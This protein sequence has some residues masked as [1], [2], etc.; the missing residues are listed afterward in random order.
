[1]DE[2]LIQTIQESRTKTANDRNEAMLELEDFR[3]AVESAK[4]NVADA[5]KRLEA[6]RVV[7]KAAQNKYLGLMNHLN[8]LTQRP[9]SLV[10]TLNDLH[11]AVSTSSIKTQQAAH[12]LGPCEGVLALAQEQLTV[13]EQRFQHLDNVLR[14]LDAHIA[15]LN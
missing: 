2:S 13:A 11:A 5:Q 1:M 3:H 4:S 10:D 9:Q 7:Q 8:T 12:A 14:E 6:A 15:Q